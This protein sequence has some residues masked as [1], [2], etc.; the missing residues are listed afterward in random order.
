MSKTNVFKTKLAYIAS[1]HIS[2]TLPKAPISKIILKHTTGATGSGGAY[3]ANCIFEEFQLRIN[4]KLFIHW[5]GEQGIA[6]AM[7]KGVYMLREFFKQKHK[8]VA[9]PAEYFIIELP[10]ALPPNSQVEIKALYASLA[11]MGCVTS[12]TGTVDILYETEDKIKG[13]TVIPYIMWGQF[14]H[15]NR[16]G[17]LLEYLT[18]MP[19][20]LRLLIMLTED[21]NTLSASTYDDIT[22]SKPGNSIFDGAI[23]ALKEKHEAKSGVALTA[24]LHMISFEGGLKV[25]ASTLKMDFYAGT[26]GT[27]KQVHWTAI[28][29]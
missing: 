29:Y 22:I 11:S 7:S 17:H 15:T 26:A 6:G 8:G 20:R 24:G 5:G 10:D 4:G 28:C 18:A 12:W 14:N 19:Y 1:G 16:T 9:M 23:S 2:E 3:V 21:G 13:R 25:P 27:T